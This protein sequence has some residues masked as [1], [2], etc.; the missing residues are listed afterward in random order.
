MSKPIWLGRRCDTDRE[1]MA[2]AWTLYSCGW[3]APEIARAL[4]VYHGTVTGWVA[5]ANCALLSPFLDDIAMDRA[6]R[7]DH[8][9]INNLSIYEYREFVTVLAR[10]G[11]HWLD[12]RW[13]A[14]P[15]QLRMAINDGVQRIR[16]GEW[17]E[18][19]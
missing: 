16:R 17:S 14:L 3:T 9:V 1:T 6:L 15:E 4:G 19:A 8:D 5:E 2:C 7:F 12:R 10:R 18:A 13:L 11:E